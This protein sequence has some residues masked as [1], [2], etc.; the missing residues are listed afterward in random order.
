MKC[1]FLLENMGLSCFVLFGDYVEK[2]MNAVIVQT[3]IICVLFSLTFNPIGTVVLS[4]HAMSFKGEIDGFYKVVSVKTIDFKLRAL[5]CKKTGF[6][7]GSES[8]S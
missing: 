5:F 7:G 4:D 6:L 2:Y 8:T 3:N 1:Q